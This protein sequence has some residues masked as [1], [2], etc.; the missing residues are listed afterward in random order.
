MAYQ[1]ATVDL[2]PK[3]ILQGMELYV[4][5]GLVEGIATVKQFDKNSS[6]GQLLAIMLK[7]IELIR[8]PLPAAGQ[9]QPFEE[10]VEAVCAENT[11]LLTTA[12]QYFDDAQVSPLRAVD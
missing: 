1:V 12:M 8:L 5:L 9:Q 6:R 11:F 7:L 3:V 4:D 10:F 2:G